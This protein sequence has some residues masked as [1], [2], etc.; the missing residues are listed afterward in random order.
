M[1]RAYDVWENNPL[2]LPCPTRLY[3]LAPI[4]V[5]TPMVE[6]LT[7]YIVRLAETHCVSAGL[8]YWKEIRPLAGKGNIFTFRI[9][10]DNGYSTHT[11][12]GLGAPAADFVRVL[13]LLTGRRN[14]RFL[15]LLTWAQVLPRHSLLRRSRAWCEHC[16]QAW[17]RAKQPMYE[18]LLW[19]LQAVTV[20]PYHRCLL[21]HVCPH[22]A[23]PVGPLDWRSRAA[24]CSRCE[25]TLVPRA[26]SA[27]RQRPSTE[28]RWATWVARTVGELLAAAPQI[29]CPPGRARLAQTISLC[30]EH[31][32][33]GNASA[34]ARLL[35]VGRGAISRWQRGK[36]VPQFALLLSM[37]YRLGTSLLDFL[38]GAPAA[39]SSGGFVRSAPV[40]SHMPA[41][42]STAHYGRRLNR[43]VVSQIL[44]AALAESPPPSV[45]G[46][47]R[48]LG[49]AKRTVY[50]HFPEL[51]HAIAKQY[52]E[53]RARRALTRKV[54]AAEEVRRVAY[55]LHAHGISLTRQN[56]RPLL[57][58]SDY[59][60]LAEGRAALR[61]VRSQLG[62]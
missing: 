38:L 6:S 60:N 35:Q 34:F 45:S 30:I 40:E 23:K 48:R 36:A 1:R 7:G 62:L 5:G 57:T 53:H 19:T 15:T 13:E 39:I 58:S 17:H 10:T 51:C 61:E 8:L 25:Q 12:N 24:Y 46:V 21:R 9:T 44:H 49:Y 43:P 47:M 59:L 41:R 42:R 31:T 22:C 3:S 28:L 32:S 29:S 26:L 20:C 33:A 50:R 52:A 37:V 56:L 55:W 54:H 27:I 14:L 11:I 2:V 16:L 18:P 4:G